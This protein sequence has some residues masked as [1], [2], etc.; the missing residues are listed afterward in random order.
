TA[1]VAFSWA[2]RQVKVGEPSSISHS[3]GTSGPVSVAWRWM[4]PAGPGAG[5]AALAAAS[6]TWGLVMRSRN[7]SRASAARSGPAVKAAP[8]VPAASARWTRRAWAGRRGPA[9]GGR[10]RGGAGGEGGTAR[11][12]GVG[13]VDEEVVGGAAGPGGG[14]PADRPDLGLDPGTGRAQGGREAAGGLGQPGEQRG[15]V[16]AGRA[17]VVRGP[18]RGVGD[19]LAGAEGLLH[20]AEV[21]ADVADQVGQGPVGGGGHG[22][23]QLGALEGGHQQAGLVDDLLAEAA[24]LQAAHRPPLA[25]V[26]C[27]AVTLPSGAME[28]AKPV[29]LTVDDDPGVSRAVARDLRRRY[30]QDFRVVRAESGPQ[31][32]EALAQIKL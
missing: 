13:A 26:G 6:A 7:S 27:P 12:G 1:T 9:G 5:P 17:A 14:G 4:P 28:A 16:A 23:R 20:R 25:V 8:T 24:V 10:G 32:L 22:R 11:A 18:A 19:G 21:A 15:G 31:A 3:D 30:G 2:W 29:L